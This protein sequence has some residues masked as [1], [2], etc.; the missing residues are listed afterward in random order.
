MV[1]GFRYVDNVLWR[2]GLW[3]L[4]VLSIAAAVLCFSNLSARGARRLVTAAVIVFAPALLLNLLQP[5]VEPIAAVLLLAFG[6]LAGWAAA[7]GNAAAAGGL[8][9]IAAL[10]GLWSV[11]SCGFALGS[12]T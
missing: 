8:A 9:V 7:D 1:F 5:V 3:V 6:I 4:V 12:A 2:P 10:F 11:L